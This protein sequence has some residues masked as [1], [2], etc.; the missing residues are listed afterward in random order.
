[1]G[2]CWGVR[3]LVSQF[4]NFTQFI[5]LKN[6]AIF[7]SKKKHKRQSKDW[8]QQNTMVQKKSGIRTKAQKKGRWKSKAQHKAEATTA[9]PSLVDF[10]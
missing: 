6:N 1:M 8:Q 10:C 3:T 2:Y 9:V 5:A 7:T 4:H